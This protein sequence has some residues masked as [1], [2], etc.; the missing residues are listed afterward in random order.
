M[1]KF[2]NISLSTGEFSSNTDSHQYH[3]LVCW[4]RGLGVGPFEFPISSEPVLGTYECCAIYEGLPRGQKSCFTFEVKRYVLPKF[5]C[6]ITPVDEIVTCG[7]GRI[8]FSV[9]ADYTYGQSVKGTVSAKARPDNDRYRCSQGEETV[10]NQINGKADLC[11]K[12]CSSRTYCW[13][14]IIIDAEVT[15]PTSDTTIQCTGQTNVP[16]R[17]RP[18]KLQILEDGGAFTPCHFTTVKVLASTLTGKPTYANVSLTGDV[19]KRK[20][21]NCRSDGETLGPLYQETDKYGIAA[22]HICMSCH[23]LNV[24]LRA[25]VVGDY[26]VQRLFSSAYSYRSMI[27]SPGKIVL[28]TND[29]EAQVGGQVNITASFSHDNNAEYYVVSKGLIVARGDCN[30]RTDNDVWQ[31]HSQICERGGLRKTCIITIDVNSFM[32]PQFAVIV[33]QKTVTAERVVI[34]VAPDIRSRVSLEFE[35]AEVRPGNETSLTIRAPPRSFIGVVAV[36]KSVYIQQEKNQLTPTKL[37]NE[38]GRFDKYN[39]LERLDSFICGWSMYCPCVCYGDYSRRT[40][41]IRK[42][43]DRRQLVVDDPV[44]APRRPGP[45]GHDRK[46]CPRDCTNP[47]FSPRHCWYFKASRYF[48]VSGITMYDDGDAFSPDECPRPNF[49][50]SADPSFG[51]DCC[52]RSSRRA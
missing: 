34:K 49:T 13:G 32:A 33:S 21:D 42:P 10:T 19:Y 16:V 18:Y 20:K 9:S 4:F 1:G 50:P 27:W 15:D 17:S 23:T 47:R 28:S 48:S 29:T 11:V 12:F 44:I 35:K 25:A 37:Y 14:D 22:F 46:C 40:D 52:Y 30:A 39:S 8:C 2:A 45:P 24:D 3:G 41:D 43:R 31:K 6:S 5:S 7:Q 38:A 36:D 26:S 51:Y